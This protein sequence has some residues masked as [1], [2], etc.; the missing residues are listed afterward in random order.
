MPDGIEC[1]TDYALLEKKIKDFD[2]LH[3]FSRMG[4]VIESKVDGRVVYGI[5]GNGQAGEVFHPNSVFVSRNHAKRHGAEAFVYNGLDPEELEFSDQAR[6]NRFLFLSKTSLKVKNLKGAF[7]LAAD[8]GQNLWIA[9]GERPY[10]L[11][12]QT[13]LKKLLGQDWNWL[14]SVDQKQKAKFLVSGKAMIFPL[15]WNEPFGLVLTESLVSGTPVFANPYG[16]VPEILEFA[17][18]C[19]MKNEE[20]WIQALTGE[21][22]TPDPKKCRDWVLA[23]FDQVNMAKGFLA[24]YEKVIAGEKLNLRVPETLVGATE[25]SRLES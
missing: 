20:D 5:H 2:I 22:R 17:P 4:E 7:R 25:T 11:R 15:L 16:A 21:I 6:P 14:G 19:L 18:E 13:E 3:G 8:H 1:I 10:S 12:L 24:L 23:H 9:G